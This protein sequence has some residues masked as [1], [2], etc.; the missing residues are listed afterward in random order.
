MD[1]NEGRMPP[2][3]SPR[4]SLDEV[5]AETGFPVDVVILIAEVA[6]VMAWHIHEARIEEVPH[7]TAAGFCRLLRSHAREQLGH[8]AASA[9]E[10]WGVYRSEDVGRIV[11]ALVAAGWLEASEDDTQNDF[12]ELFIVRDYFGPA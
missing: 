8:E 4:R 11:F 10:E 2:E 7:L 1:G 3:Q 9:F 6:G 12:N 5:A